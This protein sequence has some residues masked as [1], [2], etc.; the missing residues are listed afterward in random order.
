M[1]T[2]KKIKTG[3]K[4]ILSSILCLLMIAPYLPTLNVHAEGESTYR[5]AISC[6]DDV[7]VGNLGVDV[8]L[9]GDDGGNLNANGTMRIEPSKGE[10]GNA[11]EGYFAGSQFENKDSKNLNVYVADAGKTIDIENSYIKINGSDNLLNDSNLSLLTRDEEGNKGYIFTSDEIITSFDVQIHIKNNFNNGPEP[12]PGPQNGNGKFKVKVGIG[13][14]IPEGTEPKLRV[15]FTK[16]YYDEVAQEEKQELLNKENQWYSTIDWT[17]IPEGA[18]HVT[19][20]ARDDQGIDYDKYFQNGYVE[21]FHNGER[22]SQNS[23]KA[24]DLFD[25]FREPLLNENGDPIIENGEEVQCRLYKFEIDP[26]GEESYEF[27]VVFSYTRSVSWSYRPED[28]GRDNFVQNCKIYLLG[29]DG[30]Y[31]M[32]ADEEQDENVETFD[33]TN[34]QLEIGQ[35]YK[36]KIVP[37]YGYQ[38]VGL[39]IGGYTIVPSDVEGDV[40]VFEFT[41]EDRNFHF[42]GVVRKEG[43][44]GDFE[45]S[46][47]G[48][49]KLNN[50]SIDKADA[51]S[52]FDFDEDMGGSIRIQSKDNKD[53]KLVDVN[54][55]NINNGEI[56][57]GKVKVDEDTNEYYIGKSYDIDVDQVVSKGGDNG[58]WS[59]PITEAKGEVNISF[60]F[61]GEDEGVT[62]KIARKHGNK[63]DILDATF[64]NGFLSFK[65]NKFSTFTILSSQEST[66]EKTKFVF[67]DWDDSGELDYCDIENEA[68]VDNSGRKIRPIKGLEY[69]NG[70][71]Y[72]TGDNTDI[73]FEIDCDASELHSFINRK[74]D[75]NKWSALYAISNCLPSSDAGCYV[76]TNN[77]PWFVEDRGDENNHKFVVVIPWMIEDNGSVLY[78]IRDMILAKRAAE[79]VILAGR[80]TPFRPGALV[81]NNSEL[82][83]DFDVQ[84]VDDEEVAIADVSGVVGDD[85]VFIDEANAR[86]GKIRFRASVDDNKVDE[87][88]FPGNVTLSYRIVEYRDVDGTIYK[89][90]R[91][92]VNDIEPVNESDLPFR[93]NGGYGNLYEVEIPSGGDDFA[94]SYGI[95]I[96]ADVE[97]ITCLF[98]EPADG[99][100]YDR[101]AFNVT[102]TSNSVKASLNESRTFDEE[103]NERFPWNIKVGSDVTIKFSPK[104]EFDGLIK[105]K[106]LVVNGKKINAKNGVFSFKAPVTNNLT[107]EVFADPVEKLILTDENDNPIVANKNLYTIN[108]ETTFKAYV[109]R[110]VETEINRIG[111]SA[112][113]EPD[114]DVFEYNTTPRIIS[115]SFLNGKKAIASKDGITIENGI[116]ITTGE[117]LGVAGQKI[118][119]VARTAN[120]NISANVQFTAPILGVKIEKVSST[121]ETKL[122]NNTL[123]DIYPINQEYGTE[124]SY[125]VTFY[126]DADCKKKVD[127]SNYDDI[128]I[129]MFDGDDFSSVDDID[130]G[131]FDGTTLHVDPSLYTKN[132]R[133]PQE[134]SLD[135]KNS[136]F[137]FYIN[138]E[139]IGKEGKGIWKINFLSVLDG[140][141]PSIKSNDKLSTNHF[142]GVSLA[143]PKGVKANNNLY[144]KI[145]AKRLNASDGVEIDDY[146]EETTFIVSSNQKDVMLNV[147]NDSLP[148]DC[149]GK[150]TYA[151]QCQMLYSYVD[152]NETYYFE[153]GLPSFEDEEQW[154]QTNTKVTK[155][156]TKLGAVKKAPSKIYA[157]ENG[158]LVGMPKYSATTTAQGLEEVS[159]YDSNGNMYSRWDS[160]NGRDNNI[161]FVDDSLGYI[162]V[163]TYDENNYSYL[164][165][166]KYK[167]VM[168]A[169]SGGGVPASASIDINVVSSIDCISFDVPERITKAN[170]KNATFKVTSLALEGVDGIKP[171]KSTL[172]W[173]IGDSDGQPLDESNPIYGMVTVKNGAVTISKDYVLDPIDDNNSFTVIAT[174]ADYVGNQNNYVSNKI[175]ITNEYQIPTT[176][177]F[178]FERWEWDDIAQEDV[179]MGY[180]YSRI[181]EESIKNKELFFSQD[182]NGS[183]IIVFDQNDRPI[184]DVALAVSGAKMNGD[185]INIEKAGKVTVK[186]T[187]KDGGN[188]N[189]SISFKVDYTDSSYVFNNWITDCTGS[190]INNDYIVDARAVKGRENYITNRYNSV[191]PIALHVSGCR[192]ENEDGTGYYDSGYINHSKPSVT[193]GKLAETY[194]DFDCVEYVI[195]PTAENTTIKITDNTK[196]RAKE[197]HTYEIYNSAVKSIDA[198]K[199]KGNKNS[200]YR[201]LSYESQMAYGIESPNS[202]TYT[203]DFG[204]N[205]DIL[206]E[207]N[208]VLVTFDDVWYRYDI[209]SPI[210]RNARID[211]FEQASMEGVIFDLSSG[212]AGKNNKRFT[213]DFFEDIGG[214]IE[215]FANKGT[216]SFYATAGTKEE[217]GT[218]TPLSKPVKVDVKIVDNHKSK[219]TFKTS[220]Y[221]LKKAIVGEGRVEGNAEIVAPTVANGL[222]VISDVRLRSGN[223]KGDIN[224][225]CCVFDI[226]TL[227]DFDRYRLIDSSDKLEIVMNESFGFFDENADEWVPTGFDIVYKDYRYYVSS[228]MDLKSLKNGTLKG[229]NNELIG[230]GN[231]NDS[232]KKSLQ[233]AAYKDWCKNNLNGTIEWI[234]V[235][236]G[237]EQRVFQN[238]SVTIDKYLD[239]INGN[240]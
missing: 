63:V 138:G 172:D 83:I 176:I 85:V 200:I 170:G 51:K 58:Y 107:V 141:S 128:S 104:A 45:A 133:N 186:A 167:V 113:P 75:E 34:Y 97:Y 70:A 199:I 149:G 160:N 108:H 62:Y 164:M 147:A 68:F 77:P 152:N 16:E 177:A 59:E 88:G 116:L 54:D 89:S 191:K 64:S 153:A 20:C 96:N 161:L 137:A 231:A 169:V 42:N 8:A 132:Y 125:R 91:P 124:G 194:Y 198:C 32:Y 12:G 181:S 215:Y 105:I 179:F 134:G 201:T 44:I 23:E 69:E 74:E 150:V 228:S 230:P 178:A 220:K 195:Y 188:K 184:S 60:A 216:Q 136:Y 37:D 118:S 205:T 65:T 82:N 43:T 214:R 157:G 19:I 17:D 151:L 142:V 226:R 185:T 73:E 238:I 240:E 223:V 56:D 5:F 187:T 127:I 35:H 38:V 162:Y 159:L 148:N 98:V 174:A 78:P 158:V 40:G 219:V 24:T 57:N 15:L 90:Y 218:F 233:Q 13:K 27:P 193:G 4:R 175:L 7:N 143:L 99:S 109:A 207:S 117:N 168:T 30:K 52:A 225:F 49:I 163:N 103:G 206:N 112:T 84:E 180:D 86:D 126:S 67:K 232:Q 114:D 189:K 183:W 66:S 48:D 235:E 131:T 234:V 71:Y 9:L 50:S 29:D 229:I 2:K 39:Y 237:T 144:Y 212:D 196:G 100:A 80:N 208:A 41:M 102:V 76:P 36:I 87:T 61:N 101:N 204:K 166:G 217:N 192:D 146:V 182:I 202:V 130:F 123:W 31:R 53:F 11:D 203:V 236:Y 25:A 95:E 94:I 119:L 28:R 140:K 111:G 145:T 155:Y 46:G 92:G 122:F 139:Q 165:P 154:L 224:Q 10:F 93:V 18:T 55:A 1:S 190:V 6:D 210:I 72:Y 110:G 120:K 197:I 129:K 81:T 135:R 115:E 211:D 213:I 173:S 222:G 239:S 3:L 156:E 227:K 21:V 14:Y 26:Y 106:Y 221:N 121:A 209:S 22:I 171:D 33:F 79:E 47:I